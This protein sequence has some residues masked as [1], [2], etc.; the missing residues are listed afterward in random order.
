MLTIFFLNLLKLF[1]LAGSTWI[2]SFVISII[3]LIVYLHDSHKNLLMFEVGISGK[4]IENLL[5]F[6]H[7]RPE[8]ELLIILIKIL[9]YENL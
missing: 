1:Y 6:F 4:N 5:N 9:F 8:S 7:I 3:F 2:Q